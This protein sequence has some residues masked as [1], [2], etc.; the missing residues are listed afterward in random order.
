LVA[1]GVYSRRKH[2]KGSPIGFVLALPSNSK[3]Q[4]ERVTKGKPSS[5]LGL[6]VSDK[7]KKFYNIDNRTNFKKATPNWKKNR[8]R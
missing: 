2:L 7:R 3:A 5:L 6:V 1:S 8:P 4:V